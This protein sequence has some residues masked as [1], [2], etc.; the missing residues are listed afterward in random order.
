[1]INDTV[2][3]SVACDADAGDIQEIIFQTVCH[4]ISFFTTS[5]ILFTI[6]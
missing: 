6:L 3:E 4:L 1:M 2:R 5:N